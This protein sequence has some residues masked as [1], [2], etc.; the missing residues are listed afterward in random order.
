MNCPYCGTDNNSVTG[1]YRRGNTDRNEIRRYRKCDTCGASFVTVERL[2][3]P[4]I[5]KEMENDNRG[6]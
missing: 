1:H 2:I 5:E 3:D 6:D 4:R